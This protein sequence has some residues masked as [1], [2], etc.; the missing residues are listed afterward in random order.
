MRSTPF[1]SNWVVMSPVF[2]L[3]S[4]TVGERL[5]R[6]HDAGGVGRGVARRAL[7]P[8]RDV[9]ELLDLGVLLVGLLERRRLREG[10][11]EGHLE[12]E[13]DHLRDLVDL[14]V[15]HVHHAADVAHD[16]LRLHR[17]E[18][19]DLG[20]VLAAVLL[21]DVLDDLAPARLA[22]VD[23]DVGGADALLVQEAL[24]DEVVLDRV[25]V[26]DAQGS[27]RRGCRRPSRG[28]GP[29]GMPLLPRVAD[30][31][32][33]DEEVAREAD[34]LDDA[35]LLVEPRL[36]VREGVAQPA[37]RG[38]R[39]EGPA[40]LGEA[41]AGDLLEVA[42]DRE[43][44]RHVEGGERRHRP[45]SVKSHISAIWTVERERLRVVGE[46]PRHLLARTSGRTG[47]CRSAAAPRRPP[48]CPSRCTAARRGRGGRPGAGSGRRWWPTSVQPRLLPDAQEP[49]VDPPL[50]G[51]AVVHHLEVEAVLAEDL[52]EAPDAARA[53]RPPRRPGCAARSR[54]RGSRRGRSRPSLCLASS[55][56][57]MRG[58]W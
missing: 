57:S 1:M 56:L 44:R 31:V 34:P 27:R 9:D 55:S 2:P 4:G 51:D 30:E 48:S 39:V 42:V 7:E 21:R 11:V 36:V 16:G 14:G 23:V 54:P 35:D 26:G 6:D 49:L 46:E 43:A 18:G 22:E 24:E 53:P 45:S 20:H 37:R 3:K 52:G 28:P 32:P 12:V 17:P 10:L 8:A 50:V 13:R 29:T 38:Q 15:A 19:D 47:S 5:R 33:D 58:R 40:P 25:D 41:V